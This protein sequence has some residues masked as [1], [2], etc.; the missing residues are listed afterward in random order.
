MGVFIA[1]D[2]EGADDD[3]GQ[4]APTGWRCAAWSP[5]MVNSPRPQKHPRIRISIRFHPEAT[6]P[7]GLGLAA[8]VY[9]LSLLYERCFSRSVIRENADATRGPKDR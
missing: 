5:E 1:T 4:A 8:L 2:A 6:W 7:N 9:I 3:R